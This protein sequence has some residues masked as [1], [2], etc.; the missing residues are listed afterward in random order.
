LISADEFASISANRAETEIFPVFFPVSREFGRETG[1]IPTASATTRLFAGIR[2]R[3]SQ[4]AD[5]SRN[6][7][8]AELL[9]P[10]M[11]AQVRL[12]MLTAASFVGIFVGIKLTPSTKIPTCL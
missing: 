4:A 9:R 8:V 6:Y 11:S 3:P 7:C 5:G 10:R 1:S 2:R 12:T